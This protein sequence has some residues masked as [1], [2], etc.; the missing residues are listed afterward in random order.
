MTFLLIFKLL[1]N[2]CTYTLQGG[3]VELSA[4]CE[5]GSIRIDVQDTSIGLSEMGKP[6]VFT[7]F[8]YDHYNPLRGKV[9]YSSGTGLSLAIVKRLV[10][11][12]GGLIWFE[13]TEG[14]GSTFSFT[15]PV[16]PEI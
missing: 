7:R 12:H 3:H 11:L 10:E 16:A 15:L 14:Q 2:A 6:Y 1:D 13:S 9:Q 4:R 8:F 5:H